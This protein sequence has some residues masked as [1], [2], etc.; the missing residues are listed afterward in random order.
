MY[1]VI[2]QIAFLWFVAPPLSSFTTLLSFIS[3]FRMLDTFDSAMNCHFLY[4]YMVTNYTNPLTLTGP[5]WAL[6]EYSITIW[7]LITPQEWCSVEY[8]SFQLDFNGALFNTT[9]R[10]LMSL[11][12]WIYKKSIHGYVHI[13]QCCREYNNKHVNKKRMNAN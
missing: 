11:S 8:N 9:F 13:W 1:L 5:W 2:S 10:R 12:W 3:L 7:F 4:Y 6:W